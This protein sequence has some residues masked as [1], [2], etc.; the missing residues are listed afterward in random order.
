M[1]LKSI[2]IRFYKSFNFNYLRKHNPNAKEKPWEK[3]TIDGTDRWYPF[4]SVPI[5]K[6][7]TAVVGA[8]ESGK[9]HLLS[10]IEKAITGHDYKGKPLDSTDFCRYSEL[11]LV[12]SNKRLPDFVTEWCDISEAQRQIIKESSGIHEDREFDSFFLHR[13]SEKLLVIYLLENSIY[14]P[15][16]KISLDKV[17]NFTRIL[18][19]TRRLESTVALPSSIPIQKLVQKINGNI[20]FHKYDILPNDKRRDIRKLIDQL[21]NNEQEITNKIAE[22]IFVLLNSDENL[23]DE[24]RDKQKREI[25]LTHDLLVKIG[26]INLE[27]L[28]DL[29][30]SMNDDNTGYTQALVDQINNQLA[31]NLNFPNYWVQDNKFRLLMSA[32]DHNIE[33]FIVDRTGTK[34]SFEERSNGLKYFLS[35]FIQHRAYQPQN[36]VPEILLMDEP[37]AFLSNR[38]QQDLLKIFEEVASGEDGKENDKLPSQV[39]YVTHSPFLIDK[40]HAERIRVLDKGSDHEGT[41]VINSS[42]VNHYEPLRSALGAFV[43]ETVYISH[44][45]L[46]VEGPSDQVLLAG[47]STYLRK[48][49]NATELESLDLNKITIVPAA[50]ASQ[51]PYLTFLARGRDS[52]QPAVIVLLDN[53]I[54]GN[55]A[56]EALTKSNYGFRKKPALEQEFILQIGDLSKEEVIF[57]KKLLNPEIEDL[58][59]IP[60]AVLAAKE[61]AREIC[62]ANQYD[63]EHIREEFVKDRVDLG[64]TMFDALNTCVKECS[65]EHEYHLDKIGFARTVIDIVN[66]LNEDQAK[67]IEKNEASEKE[68]YVESLNKFE[69][70][71]KK[72]FQALYE[73]KSNAEIERDRENATQKVKDLEENFFHNHHKAATRVDALKLLKTMERL[74]TQ[75]ERISS[76]KIKGGISQIRNRYRLDNDLDKPVDDYPRFKHDVEGLKYLPIQEENVENEI[77]VENPTPEKTISVMSPTS[78]KKKIKQTDSQNK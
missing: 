69:F 10:A 20:D 71:F 1:R 11:F 77:M 8:N 72:L 27:T 36:N 53:D 34:Y 49:K 15:P 70:N 28:I 14:S 26:K 35:Y 46:I 50:G 30:R 24:K 51:I 54:S 67:R 48:F 75:D 42:H 62:N 37:D 12:T 55:K 78:E 16:Y 32:K 9:S 7:I 44:C 74:L 38:A 47:A 21:S 59:P 60:I 17:D 3:I 45:N 41:I 33:F 18:P 43:A 6:K 56:K 58:I 31:A 4:I 73:K 57:S 66:K 63:I 39:V 40:N 65:R 5:D 25:D 68:K 76:Q 2:S 61:Y 52:N 23:E 64:E 13:T 29:A 22:K 19:K